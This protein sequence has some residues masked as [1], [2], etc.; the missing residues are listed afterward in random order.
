MEISINEWRMIV[1]AL[2]KDDQENLQ[3]KKIISNRTFFSKFKKAIQVLNWSGKFR[4]RY[5]NYSVIAKIKEIS[6]TKPYRSS[7][8][9]QITMDDCFF[10]TVWI[11]MNYSNTFDEL[12]ME[13][14][15]VSKPVLKDETILASQV[16]YIEYSK[17][18]IMK[19]DKRGSD[20]MKKR[21]KILNNVMNQADDFFDSYAILMKSLKKHRE[22]LFFLDEV[23]THNTY[24]IDPNSRD[25]ETIL[26]VLKKIEGL[27]SNDCRESIL[28]IIQ[29][30]IYPEVNSDCLEIIKKEI[31]K[32]FKEKFPEAKF[33]Q[34]D[35][36]IQIKNRDKLSNDCKKDQYELLDSLTSTYNKM[37]EL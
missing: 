34:Q 20:I 19:E 36:N 29:E 13:N 35:L 24:Q 28:K 11:A 32:L 27:I 31:K 21:E 5:Q 10:F 2:E 12:I 8:Y 25:L 33:L 37:S 14:R 23:V 4:K 22:F 16:E 7:T 17:N 1:P 26:R 18:R 30:I 9:E 6:E 3:W 15:N